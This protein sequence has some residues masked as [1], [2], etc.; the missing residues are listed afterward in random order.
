MGHHGGGGR[1]RAPGGCQGGT[2]HGGGGQGAARGGHF[3]FTAAAEAAK[4]KA[5]A[6]SEW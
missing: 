1:A 3:D 5:R 2:H 6:E 4:A